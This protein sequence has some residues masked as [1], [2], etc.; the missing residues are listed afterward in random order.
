MRIIY[1]HR[2]QQMQTHAKTILCGTFGD[3]NLRWAYMS[4][5]T[6]SDVVAQI[7]LSQEV[8]VSLEQNIRTVVTLM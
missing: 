8:L 1:K 4:E 5:S 6:F 3:L 2:F 7:I